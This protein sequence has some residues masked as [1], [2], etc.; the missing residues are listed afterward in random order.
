MSLYG[1]FLRYEWNGPTFVVG[2]YPTRQI[3]ENKLKEQIKYDI[4]NEIG[5]EDDYYILEVPYDGKVSLKEKIK[6]IRIQ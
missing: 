1:I 4:H 5:D 2:L 3:A 6:N